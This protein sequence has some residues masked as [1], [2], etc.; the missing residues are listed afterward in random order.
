LQCAPL[1][2]SIPLGELAAADAKRFGL[3]WLAHRF[4]NF[5]LTVCKL[6]FDVFRPESSHDALGTSTADLSSCR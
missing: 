1:L 6:M 3:S 5:R 4:A 2:R